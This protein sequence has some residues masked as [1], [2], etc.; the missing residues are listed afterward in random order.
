MNILSWGIQQAEFEVCCEDVH[1]ES[2]FTKF[3]DYV[4]NHAETFFMDAVQRFL[5]EKEFD[6]L[7][8]E[9]LK[10]ILTGVSFYLSE[11]QRSD[12]DAFE[13]SIQL[14]MRPPDFDCEYG[15]FVDYA[16]KEFVEIGG[17]T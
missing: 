6:I 3:V 5:T 11:E 16:G 12:E 2:E 13:W 15:F 1:E 17:A 4:M 10:K 9:A 8:P 7:T 14:S